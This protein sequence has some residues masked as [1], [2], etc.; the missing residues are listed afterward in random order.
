MLETHI[1]LYLMQKEGASSLERGVAAGWSLSFMAEKFGIPKAT[2]YR[3][4]KSLIKADVI[5]KRQRNCYALSDSYRK[6]CNLQKSAEKVTSD[7]SW[8]KSA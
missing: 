5:Y 1:I 2:F 4:V 3:S 8:K 7:Y 6:L